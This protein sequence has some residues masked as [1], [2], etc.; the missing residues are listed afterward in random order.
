MI[1]IFVEAGEKEGFALVFKH[2]FG[3]AMEMFGKRMF[4]YELQMSRA[5]NEFRRVRFEV[6]D[7]G[8]FNNESLLAK[9]DFFAQ[10]CWPGLP[11]FSNASAMYEP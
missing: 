8:A 2:S 11:G 7:I 4:L 9:L 5:R 1:G 10:D 6:G 3:L